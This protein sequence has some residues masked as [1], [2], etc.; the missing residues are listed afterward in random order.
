VIVIVI[1]TSVIV[2][3]MSAAEDHHEAVSAWLAREDADLATTPLIVAELDHLVAT[4]GGRV[5]L[6]AFA[7][8]S[9]PAGIWSSGGRARSRQP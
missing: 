6:S 8:I 1:D 9:S 7:P 2:A 5:A 4:R 3:Y